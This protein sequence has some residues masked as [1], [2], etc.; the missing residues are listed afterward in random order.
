M[1]ANLGKKA[2]NRH[3]SRMDKVIYQRVRDNVAEFMF[4]MCDIMIRYLMAMKKKTIDL[5]TIRYAIETFHHVEKTP[6]TKHSMKRCS[7]TAK[8]TGE[9]CF[10]IPKIVFMRVL[11]YLLDQFKNEV[12]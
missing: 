3:I 10:S 4:R 2:T 9:T 8:L 6:I 12:R 1:I 7:P 11:K 5:D